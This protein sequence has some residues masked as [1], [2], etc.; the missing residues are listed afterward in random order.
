MP[1]PYWVLRTCLLVLLIA[2]L[3]GLARGQEQVP[4]HNRCTAHSKAEVQKCTLS[5]MVVSTVGG[6]PV[7]KATV[8]LFPERAGSYEQVQ[9]TITDAA[10]HVGF[11]D[12]AA[13]R[14]ALMVSQPSCVSSQG[15]GQL[16][17]S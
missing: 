17:R 10:G 13:G 15:L 12:L 3:G 4:A 9:S 5:G 11:G 6:P 1:V 2:L 7:R 8:R 14:Y 16:G